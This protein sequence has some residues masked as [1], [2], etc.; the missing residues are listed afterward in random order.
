MRAEGESVRV[1]IGNPAVFLGG[2]AILEDDADAGEAKE[3]SLLC[4]WAC[5]AWRASSWARILVNASSEAIWVKETGLEWE[6]RTM[7]VKGGL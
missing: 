6:G 1:G 2:V 5:D 7:V 4:I 3:S